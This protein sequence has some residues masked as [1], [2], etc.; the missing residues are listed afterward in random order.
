[1]R[2]LL[3]KAGFAEVRRASFN[4]SGDPMFAAVEDEGRFF[5]D[6]HPELAMQARKA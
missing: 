1:M 3:E 5:D 6:G 2:T 4:D